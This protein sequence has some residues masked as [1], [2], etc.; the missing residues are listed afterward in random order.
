MTRSVRLLAAAVILLGGCGGGEPA[1]APGSTTGGSTGGSGSGPNGTASA[2]SPSGA[3]QPAP[4]RLTP[5]DDGGQFT[6]QM[7]TTST[8]RVDDPAA[9]DP[10]VVGV[11]V[12]VV[13]VLNVAASGVREWELRAVAP[14]TTRLTS[15]QPAYTLT[16]TV[17]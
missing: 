17:P 8:L 12:L 4:K 1:G 2:P 5:K 10:A 3:P 6:M 14:G 11:S 7:G 15:R 9:T 13:P 16:I